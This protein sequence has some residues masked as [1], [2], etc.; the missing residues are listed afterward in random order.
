MVVFDFDVPASDDLMI[1]T[2]KA[3]LP[4]MKAADG[5]VQFAERVVWRRL[6]VKLS[7]NEIKSNASKL[8][9]RQWLLVICVIRKRELDRELKRAEGD[10]LSIRRWGSG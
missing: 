7:P 3:S 10:D 5:S 2:D 6:L 9:T 1:L 4:S 8:E